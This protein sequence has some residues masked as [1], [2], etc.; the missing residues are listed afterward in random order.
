MTMTTRPTAGELDLALHRLDLKYHEAIG[1]PY[2]TDTTITEARHA[3][4]CAAEDAEKMQEMREA[5]EKDRDL[6]AQLAKGEAP[7]LAAS[8]RWCDLG[9]ILGGDR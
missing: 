7:N 6:F 3:L 9:A 5:L 8:A 2:I 4:R 1:S